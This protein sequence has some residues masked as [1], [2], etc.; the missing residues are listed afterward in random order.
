VRTTYCVST[1]LNNKLFTEIII[2]QH[3]KFKHP[4]INDELILKLVK[5]LNG[6]K[7]TPTVNNKKFAYFV[8]DPHYLNKKPYRLIITL[9]EGFDYIGVINAFRVKE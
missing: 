7:L 1:V 9:E 3:Y 4:D 8:L 2:D 6:L 5:L